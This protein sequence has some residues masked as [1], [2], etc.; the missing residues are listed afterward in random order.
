MKGSEE[1][2][3]A[4]FT[5]KNTLPTSFPDDPPFDCGSGV[6]DYCN[7]IWQPAT[8]TKKC[9]NAPY[10]VPD[11]LKTGHDEF[12]PFAA[13]NNGLGT[14]ASQSG[15]SACS[16]LTH[17]SADNVDN[18]NTCYSMMYNNKEY[19]KQYLF[20]DYLVVRLQPNEN[21]SGDADNGSHKLNGKFLFIYKD[22]L[23]GNNPHFPQASQMTI[24]IITTLFFQRRILGDCWA[25]A[26][27][28]VPSMGQRR[29]VEKFATS[30][31]MLSYSTIKIL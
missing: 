2:G 5:T 10:F 26:F 3:F 8:A 12:E 11:I 25:I 29:I 17:F 15:V 31:E 13:P 16:G 1:K 6:R 19:R 24:Y 4:G 20:N 18:M 21:A 30:T 22:R 27:G 28:K 23:D 9:G 14:K 7:K